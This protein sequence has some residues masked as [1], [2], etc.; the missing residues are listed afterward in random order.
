[1]KLIISII[2]LLFVSTTLA[3]GLGGFIN[4]SIKKPPS[5]PQPKPVPP[6]PPVK[7]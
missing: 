5:A 3:A 2:S 6:A 4:D 1:M 7:K